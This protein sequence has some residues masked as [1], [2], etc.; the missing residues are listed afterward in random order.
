MILLLVLIASALDI[1]SIP[2]SLTPPTYRRSLN[3][4]FDEEEAIYLFG[5]T[6]DSGETFSNEIWKFDLVHNTWEQ[7]HSNSPVIPEPRIG[8]ALMIH[9]AVFY[10]HGGQTQYGPSSD[11]W[12]Y[13]IET[14]IWAPITPEGDFIGE[15][16]FAAFEGFELTDG[17]SIGI[18]GGYNSTSSTNSLYL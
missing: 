12:K 9:D 8:A 5:G 10:M 14:G 15:R 6:T 2:K 13:T 7:L 18:F 17:H 3:A 4:A 1:V 11:L 16:A